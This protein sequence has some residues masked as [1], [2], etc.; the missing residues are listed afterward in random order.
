VEGF[1]DVCNA[2]GLTGTQG[3]LIPDQNVKDLML[4]HDVVDAV[5]AGKF[6]VYAVGSIDQG[7][8]I[9]TGKRSGVRGRAGTFTPGSV[10]ARVDAV[11]K[12]FA[13]THKAF[14]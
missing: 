7:I 6:H 2:R 1:F 12:K 9:L 8:E 5:R 11:L 10:H 3:V 14:D 13:R 4:R